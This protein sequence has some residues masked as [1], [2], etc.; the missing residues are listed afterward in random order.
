VWGVR[1][2]AARVRRRTGGVSIVWVKS[3]VVKQGLLARLVGKACWQGLLARLVGK[4]CWQG[5]IGFFSE[6]SSAILDS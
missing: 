3:S 4:A 1:Q 6:A 5:A 2:R